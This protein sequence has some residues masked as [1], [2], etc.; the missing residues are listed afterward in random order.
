[1]LELLY[2]RRSIRKFKNIPL[3]RE[4]IEKITKA[5]LLSPSSRSIRPWEFIIVEDRETRNLLSESKASGS[6]FLKN[7]PLAIVITADETKSDVWIED[8]SISAFIIQLEA[9]KL[10]LGSC[11]IQ[12]R[13]RK[14][15]NGEASE[16]YVKKIL[17]IPFHFRVECIIAMGYPDEQKPCYTQSDIMNQKIHYEKY[18]SIDK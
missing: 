7:A 13:N 17:N 4:R 14:T 12:I 18:S 1:M 15:A 9:E 16:T 10:G 3:E 11:W 2:G 6:A 8:A 5:A